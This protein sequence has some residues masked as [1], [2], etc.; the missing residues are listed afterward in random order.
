[1]NSTNSPLVWVEINKDIL[2]NNVK[3][4]RSIIENNTLL[5]PC[6]KANAFGHGLI[7]TSKIFLDNGADW[8]CVNSIYEAERLRKA[9]ITV[10]ILVI[11]YVQLSELV[12]VFELDLRLFVYNIETIQELSRLSKVFNKKS[13][14]HLKIDTGMSRQGVLLEN[15]EVFLDEIIN[16]EGINVEGIATHFATADSE[17]NN[18]IFI[19]Q[20]N[21]F[22]VIV[23]KV[24][25]KYGKDFILHSSNSAATLMYPYAKFHLVRPGVSIYGYYPSPE[26]KEFCRNRGIILSP[27]FSLKTKIVQIKTLAAN[28]GVSY[29][30]TFVTD[31]SVKAL[32]LPVGYYEGVT[33][34]LS[35][36]GYVTINSQKAEI[37]GRVCMHMTIVNGSKI[38]H[39]LLEDEVTV[40]GLSSIQKLAEIMDTNVNELLVSVPEEIAR[41]YV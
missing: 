17:E 28:Q 18:N 3:T 25:E 29:G 5:A 8:L 20:L 1:M 30:S 15:A 35:N 16:L 39:A 14:V 38:P 40:F 26:V 9:N 36:K 2:A 31:K 23:A 27:A 37:L 19:N 41:I 22:N 7:E 13:I 34:S 6:V 4:F 11:G 10:P 32:L 33:R 24:Q 21:S 12:K